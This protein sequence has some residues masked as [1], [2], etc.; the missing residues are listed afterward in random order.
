MAEFDVDL[1]AARVAEQAERTGQEAAA[2]FARSG[3]VVGKAEA[4]GVT[5]EV[6][7]GGLLTGLTLTRAALR[8]GSEALA[9][10]IVE[11]SRRAT[12]RA[13]DRMHQV[14][15]PVLEPEQLAELG[16]EPLRPDDPDYDDP[17]DYYG[18]GELP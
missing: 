17:D 7:P 14:L 13:G 11:L 9:G 4:A 16:Y 6:A 5:V 2:R 8:S 15:A 12:R 1:A 3:P 10:N 18:H